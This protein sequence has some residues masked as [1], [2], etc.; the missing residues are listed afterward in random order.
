MAKLVNWYEFHRKLTVKKLLLFS[1][2][3]VCRLFGT[4]R[5]AVTLLLHRYVKKG[6]I[7][8]VKRGLY[9]FPDLLPPEPLIANK[10]YAPS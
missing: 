5:A 6:F 9:A 8:R 4:T 3:D 1:A 10:M 7:V 2:T